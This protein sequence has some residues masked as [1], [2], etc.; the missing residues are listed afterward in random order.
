MRLVY[1]ILLEII[2]R[3]QMFLKGPNPAS[4][5]LY[6][7]FSEHNKNIVG[8]KFYSNG[9]SVDGVHGIR[10]RLCRMVGADKSSELCPPRGV[11]CI[12]PTKRLK[13]PEGIESDFIGYY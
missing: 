10:T 12:L 7:S 2:M 5:C 8:T 11:K 3:L 13:K 4:F 9:R 6:S 1:S